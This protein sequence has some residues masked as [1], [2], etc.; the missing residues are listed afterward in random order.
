M[1]IDHPVLLL[2]KS[3]PIK[4]I[5][6]YKDVS[7]LVAEEMQKINEN[8]M[9][10]PCIN[11][12]KCLF[13]YEYLDKRY[14]VAN[15]SYIAGDGD[16]QLIKESCPSWP[17][18]HFMPRYAVIDATYQTEIDGKLQW[19]ER[20]IEGDESLIFQHECDH[21]K[22]K[23]PIRDGYIED[24]KGIKRKPQVARLSIPR[25]SPCPCG[26]V[27]AQGKPEKYKNC[28]RRSM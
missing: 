3:N 9:A 16:V 23:H 27:N 21:L 20:T 1:I 28:C 10:A 4:N 6:D 17:G 13:V 15:P 25:N 14:V 8:S 11:I 12:L 18:E 7:T 19:I 24:S 5:E 22:G 26:K 2:R